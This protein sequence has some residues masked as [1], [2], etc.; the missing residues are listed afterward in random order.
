MI[1]IYPGNLGQRSTELPALLAGEP[2]GLLEKKDLQQ[3]METLLLQ[4]EKDNDQKS[5]LFLAT[6]EEAGGE[7]PFFYLSGMDRQQISVLQS[8]LEQAG[9]SIRCMALATPANLQFRLKDLMEEVSREAL[10][11]EKREQLADLL[12]HA[13]RQ[14]MQTSQ[15]Y[16]QCCMMAAALLQEEDLSETMLDTALQVLRAFET[17]PSND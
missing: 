5:S 11:F 12:V 8:R 4:A 7:E 16:F 3:T 2:F 14:K 6:K 1:L 9:F 13:D 10:Y 15:D 17:Q